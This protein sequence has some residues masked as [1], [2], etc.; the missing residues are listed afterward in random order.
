MSSN[1]AEKLTS[2]IG[3]LGVERMVANIIRTRITTFEEIFNQKPNQY[4]VSEN[5]IR[6][7]N[8]EFYIRLLKEK[9]LN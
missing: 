7:D 1:L 9:L 5:R 4:S 8:F 3:A 2:S 6:P